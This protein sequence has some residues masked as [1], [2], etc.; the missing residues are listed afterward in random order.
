MGLIVAEIELD[1]KD[2]T[3]ECSGGEQSEFG[4]RYTQDN[5]EHQNKA[6]IAPTEPEAEDVAKNDCRHYHARSR[7]HRFYNFLRS[8]RPN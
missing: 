8:H 1:S 3:F 2:Q 6:R 7:P 4:F 5:L